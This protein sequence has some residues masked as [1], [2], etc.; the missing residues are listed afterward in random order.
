MAALQLSRALC[1][2]RTSLLPVFFFLAGAGS[3][4]AAEPFVTDDAR[5]IERGTCKIEVGQR[6]QSQGRDVWL[7]PACNLIFDMELE[8]AHVR[9]WRD[10]EPRDSS[11]AVQAK[12]LWREIERD[13]YGLGWFVNTGF[14]RHPGPGESRVR[15]HGAALLT[16]YPVIA[17]RLTLHAN[18]GARYNRD[19]RRG[20]LTAGILAEVEIDKRFAVLAEVYDTSRSHIGWQ[21]GVRFSIVPDHLDLSI[22]R[23]GDDAA[24][25]GRR[26]WA[27]SV[28]ITSPKLTR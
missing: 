19:D 17:D 28:E 25:R 13:G 4:G 1:R 2:R 23:G 3:A 14:K 15:E 26:Y 20:E 22:T 6:G 7:L 16:T 9:S 24:F 12:G 18:V 8:F 21:A 5:I 27:V 10:D 11:R